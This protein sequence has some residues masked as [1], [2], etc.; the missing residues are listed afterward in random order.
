MYVL[1]QK[2]EELSEISLTSPQILGF[3]TLVKNNA[4]VK[5]WSAPMQQLRQ[6][7]LVFSAILR[8]TNERRISC[9]H[10]ALFDITIQRR[11]DFAIFHFTKEMHVNIVGTDVA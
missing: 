8:F 6:T 7:A 11:I 2:F 1:Y 5:F 3:V 9:V 10:D 4:T